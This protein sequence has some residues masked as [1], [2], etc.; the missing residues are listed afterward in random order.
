M[1]RLPPFTLL[2]P[3]TL[4]EAARRLAEE[5]AAE[6]RTVRLVAG[7]TDLWPNMK[8]RH[9]QADT[10]IS[11]MGVAGLAGVRDGAGD[12]GRNGA[13]GAGGDDGPRN[14]DNPRSHRSQRSQREPLRIGATTLLD[15]VAR[16]PLVAG[17]YPALAT[18]VA[19]ISSPPLRNMGTLGGNVCVDTRCTYYNQT[20]EWRRSIDYCMKAEG[21]ICWVA[22]SSP[23]CWAHSASDSAPMLCALGAAVRLVSARGERLVPVADLYRD[24]GMDYLTRRPDEILTEIEL[25]AEA[26]AGDCHTAFWKL[27]RR[28]SIDFAVLSVAAAVWTD[29]AGLVSRAS[30]YLGAVGSAPAEAAEAARLLIGQPLSALAAG[31]DLLAAAGKAARKV[32]TPM[33]NTDYQAQWRGVMAARYTEAALRELAGGERQRF[34]PQHPA[35]PVPALPQLPQDPAG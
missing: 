25:P 24:D 34:A 17:R 1:L 3:R 13:G 18:A 29:A 28:G 31:E 15:D 12:G 19:S 32:A 23:R 10:V 22:T 21:T 20:E 35:P 14:P 33:D 7:G 5:G 16:H 2:R 8:R 11:L 4:E 27:R 6:G 30:L 9:Q 26:A